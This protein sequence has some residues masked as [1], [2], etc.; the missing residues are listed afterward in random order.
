MSQ[1]SQ[2][3]KLESI[4]VSMNTLITEMKKLKLLY[5]NLNDQVD[6]TNTTAVEIKV[7]Q[8]TANQ[9]CYIHEKEFKKDFG[10]N[11]DRFGARLNS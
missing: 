1:R 3:Q 4:A 6:K 8:S 11:V 5:G 7:G 2:D 10:D 9:M